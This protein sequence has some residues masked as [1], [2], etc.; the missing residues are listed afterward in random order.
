MEEELIYKL[1]ETVENASPA[2]WEIAL[3]QARVKIITD[4]MWISLWLATTAAS[5]YLAL[6]KRRYIKKCEEEGKFISETHEIVQMLSI[7]VAAVT[8]LLAFVGIAN[9]TERTLNPEFAAIK[10]LMG[11]LKNP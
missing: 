10:V 1:I 11:L 2:L 6:V 3:K 7:V 4:A 8:L 9:I 5:A